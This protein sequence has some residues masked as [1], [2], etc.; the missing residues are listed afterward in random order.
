M[1]ILLIFVA[2]KSFYFFTVFN[3][4]LFKI[5]SIGTSKKIC[6]AETVLEVIDAAKQKLNLLSDVSYKVSTYSRTTYF[7]L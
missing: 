6:K 4:P 1:K 5:K 3:M 2:Y 7:H